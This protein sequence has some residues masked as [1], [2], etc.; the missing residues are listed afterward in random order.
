[1]TLRCATCGHENPAGPSKCAQCGGSLKGRGSTVVAGT[2]PP[3]ASGP[4][5]LLILCACVVGFFGV[6]M[7]SQ[8]TSG[9]TIVGAG[10]LFA[11]LARINQAQH[12][13]RDLH[14]WRQADKR[15]SE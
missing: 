13:H 11:V 3:T 1:M 12:H 4:T 6:I 5:I 15:A 14:A 2:A 9:P 10:L 8:A 7:A